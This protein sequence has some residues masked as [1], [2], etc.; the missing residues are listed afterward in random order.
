MN[1]NN[2]YCDVLNL[3]KNGKV[4][5]HDALLIYIYSQNSIIKYPEFDE[6]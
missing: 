6:K 3:I 5:T 4:K 2:Q 1:K